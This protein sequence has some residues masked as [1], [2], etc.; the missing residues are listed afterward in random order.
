MIT[1]IVPIYNE[2]ENIEP[3]IKE[4]FEVAEAVPI[5]EVIYVDDASTDGSWD[6][7]NRLRTQYPPLRIIRHQKNAG[8][9]A[10]LWT[11]IKAAGNDFI[12]TLDGDGQ[13]PPADIRLLWEAY[14]THKETMPRLAVLGERARRNDNWIR[15][16]SSRFANGLRASLLK[17]MTKD[18]GCSLKLFKRRDYLN[19]PYFDHMHRFLPAL[20]MREGVQLVHVSVS[21]RPRAYGQSKYGTL[22]RALVGIS[23]ILGVLWLQKRARRAHEGTIYEE[24]N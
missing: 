7:L 6:E 4:I 11:G 9:S 12:V 8:Q 13:N 1:A 14:N 15:R 10:A 19:L 24:L 22:D 20:L 21:H 23:D 18:T 3:L 2:R 17:D 16:F 5:S